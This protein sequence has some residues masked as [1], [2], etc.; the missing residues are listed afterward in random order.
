MR[1]L[2]G[3]DFEGFEKNQEKWGDDFFSQ[4]KKK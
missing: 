1:F 2:Q 4:M 3:L